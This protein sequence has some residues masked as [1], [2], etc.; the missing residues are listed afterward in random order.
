MRGKQV[1][2]EI[3]DKKCVTRE[4]NERVRLIM[5]RQAFKPKAFDNPP[6]S[7]FLAKHLV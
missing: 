2:R 4:V 5:K 3:S 1:Q 7:Y 6:I